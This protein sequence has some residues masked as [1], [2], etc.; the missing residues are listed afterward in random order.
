MMRRHVNAA[1]GL[2][3]LAS[4]EGCVASG[5]SPDALAELTVALEDRS[6]VGGSPQRAAASLPQSP[7]P[8]RLKRLPIATLVAIKRGRLRYAR[9]AFGA[10]LGAGLAQDA[11]EAGS[12]RSLLPSVP[13]RLRG[14]HLRGPTLTIRRSWTSWPSFS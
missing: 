13:H 11:L 1:F 8:A 3:L 5:P 10:A 2:L 7:P 6:R 14:Q 9:A 4:L 12:R